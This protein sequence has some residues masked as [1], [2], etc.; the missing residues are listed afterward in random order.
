MK[1]FTGYWTKEKS[2]LKGINLEVKKGDLVG[3][4]GRVGSGKSSLLLSIIGEM[5]FYRG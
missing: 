3:I 2:V 1:D 4:C 5:P